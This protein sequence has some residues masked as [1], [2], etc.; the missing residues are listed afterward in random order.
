MHVPALPLIIFHQNIITSASPFRMMSKIAPNS[1]HPCFS[2]SWWIISSFNFWKS[3][4]PLKSNAS[5]YRS[6]MDGVMLTWLNICKSIINYFKAILHFQKPVHIVTWTT[7]KCGK[8]QTS[9]SSRAITTRRSAPLHKWCLFTDALY[10]CISFKN[11]RW[12]VL[13]CRRPRSAHLVHLFEQPAL[14]T[15][16]HLL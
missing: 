15:P 1:L 6:K 3:D 10:L 11:R 2:P 8:T 16:I 5:H 7:V 4:F 14:I 9:D 13:I 12:F